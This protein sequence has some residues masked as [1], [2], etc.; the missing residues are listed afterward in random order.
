M[1]F[2]FL[3]ALKLVMRYHRVTY[4]GQSIIHFRKHWFRRT[5]RGKGTKRS[6]YT[7]LNE[8]GKLKGSGASYQEVKMKVEGR[9][10]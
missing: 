1:P 8:S 5:V 9:D 10:N 4:T 6:A 7:K 2:K 3:E